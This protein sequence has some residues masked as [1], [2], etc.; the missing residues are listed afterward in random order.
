MTNRQQKQVQPDTQRMVEGFRDT[1]YTFN[2]S[3]ADIVDNSIAAGATRVAIYADLDAAEDP[4]VWIADDGCGMDEAGLENAMRYGSA[5]RQDVHSL[6][7]FGLGLKTASTSF[8]KRLTV[9]SLTEGGQLLSATWDLDLIKERA[10]WVLDIGEATD[11]ESGTFH[12]ALGPDATHGT[13]VVWDKVDRLLKTKAGS[14]AKNKPKIMERLKN[15]LEDH[16]ATVFQRF[17]D[18]HDDRARNVSMTLNE[19]PIE[20]WDPFCEG[21]GG[22]MELKEAW[23]FENEDGVAGEVV[24][25]AFIL[26]RPEEFAT[27]EDRAYARITN[28]N[29]GIYLYRE[30]RLIEG[31]SWLGMTAADTHFN[32]LRVELSFPA[33]L[34]E[35][36]GVGIRKSGVHVDQ[37]LIDEI[38][39]VMTPVRREAEARSR[40]GR[41]PGGNVNLPSPT[42]NTI[43]RNMSTLDVAKVLASDDG[44]VTLRN[45]VG[46]IPVKDKD[47]RLLNFIRIHVD[48]GEEG[49]NVVHSPSLEDGVLWLPSLHGGRIQAQ[50]NASH[51]WYRRA[52][53]PNADNSPLVQAIDYL[54]YAL[55]QAEMNNTSQDNND[56]FEEFR[57]EVSRNLRKLVRDLPEPD[58]Q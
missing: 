12:E 50:L 17:I 6:G 21:R 43:D 55:A 48:E 19:E 53:L 45:N 23:A 15:D 22:A 30:D 29:Q 8:C 37:A 36:F 25:R 20:H 2:A 10:D 9:I 32:N 38:L 27:P 51:D 31:P 18:P 28:K 42:E 4:Y 1:G 7:R 33:P 49:L 14:E 54:L 58:Q 13:V 40:K 44:T 16:L 56:A 39:T 26:P 41:R 47:G 11:E 46:D 34:D 24:L 3:I 35:I 52:Y 5:R 57:V